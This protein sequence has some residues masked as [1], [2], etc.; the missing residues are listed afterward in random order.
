[1]REEAKPYSLG[2]SNPKWN[3]KA[4]NPSADIWLGLLS[5]KARSDLAISRDSV[6]QAGLSWLGLSDL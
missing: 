5:V 2:L 6:V 4:S 1:M 3:P